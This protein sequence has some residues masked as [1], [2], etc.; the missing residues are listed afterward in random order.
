MTV[1]WVAHCVVIAALLGL[2]AQA[3][4][5]A[6]RRLGWPVRWVWAG[7][8]L[9]SLVL[10]VANWRGWLPGSGIFS[11]SLPVVG[12]AVWPKGEVSVLVGPGVEVPATSVPYLVSF[13]PAWS[14][15][16]SERVLLVVGLLS[17]AVVLLLI[18]NSIRSL[19][20]ARAHWRPEVVEG[21]PVL[22][23]DRVGPAALGVLRGAIV[24]PEWVLSLEERYRHL[25]LLHESEHLRAGDPRLLLAA[26]LAVA[27]MPW[28]PAIWWQFLRL[29][30]ALEL[31][32]DARVLRVEPDLRGY[33]LLLLEV[34]RRPGRGIQ[35]LPAF[36]ESRTFLERRIRMLGQAH[37]RS[38]RIRAIGGV[39]VASLL[40]LLACEAREPSALEVESGKG[41]LAQSLQASAQPNQHD[42]RLL[43]T[44]N[45]RM[46]VNGKLV[47]PM[48]TVSMEYA[49]KIE[50]MVAVRDA[51]DPGCGEIQITLKE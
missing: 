45:W 13:S 10:P 43:P 1:A 4:E 9:G 20:R 25:L 23:S 8:I 21:I 14:T 33:G 31:D 35:L 40:V 6:L 22:I 27:V 5:L 46:R 30:Q 18:L 32:C 37:S 26:L 49:E 24:V 17:T 2:A 28:N 12:R 19:R 16:L 50:S 7:A 34:G 47:E 11:W 39:G 41:A 15:L 51:D 42:A 29:R 48:P 36:V 3:G 44:C 38:G